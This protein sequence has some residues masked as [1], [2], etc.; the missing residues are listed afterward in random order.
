MGSGTEA[1]RHNPDSGAVEKETPAVICRLDLAAL[2]DR[3]NAVNPSR[4]QRW[5]RRGAASLHRAIMAMTTRPLLIS[6]SFFFYSRLS[7]RSRCTRFILVRWITRG[8]PWPARSLKEKTI[9]GAR[10]IWGPG[11]VE[12][13]RLRPKCH[14]GRRISPHRQVRIAWRGVFLLPVYWRI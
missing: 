8:P 5:A 4:G 10:L 3:G 11:G 12:R 9:Q 14:T 7:G 1:Y 2:T 6:S 13:I